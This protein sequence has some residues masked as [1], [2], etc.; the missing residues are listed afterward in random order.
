MFQS[1][2][3]GN[4]TWVEPRGVRQVAC[5]LNHLVH[6]FLPETHRS[7]LV[8]SSSGGR[9]GGS[10]VAVEVRDSSVQGEEFLSSPS[11]FEAELTALP[12]P[13]PAM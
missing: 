8:P 6:G 5:D 10:G 13:C 11:S 1:P 9:D 2:C 7:A 4:L 3:P 12:L